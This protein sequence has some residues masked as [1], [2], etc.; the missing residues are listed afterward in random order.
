[1]EELLK[2]AKERYTVGTVFKSVRFGEE[3]TVTNLSFSSDNG[4]NL[5]S[6]KATIYYENEWAQIISKPEVKE[7]MNE[8]LGLPKEETMTLLEEAK[9]RFPIGTKFVPA[10][11]LEKNDDYYCIIVEEGVFEQR[12]SGNIFQTINGR[13]WGESNDP[14]CG[15]TWWNRAVYYQGNWARIIE[16]PKADRYNDGKFDLDLIP[17]DSVIEI[18][19][20]L[21]FG[22]T[23]YTPDNWKKGLSIKKCMSSLL[24][25]AFSY[26]M[27]E[28]VDPE[29]GLSHIAHIGCNVMFILWY[30]KH[31]PELYDIN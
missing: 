23:K 6:G 1:M 2:I 27:G 16:E 5:Y 25:H 4:G 22:A 24:R 10:H 19:K 8:F 12:E 28:K 15:N 14:K 26:M 13:V 3:H 17:Y 31:K 20:V 18:S 11:L 30:E 21:T 9:K 7:D 29:T